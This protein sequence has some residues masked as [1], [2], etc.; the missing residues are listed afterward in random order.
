MSAAAAL[1][2]AARSLLGP[3]IAVCCREIG[4][5]AA[6]LHGEEEAAIARA[7][8]A[9]RA[10]FAAGRAAARAAM[11][12]LGHAPA[13]IPMGGDRAPLWP[14]P[15]TGSITHAGGLALAA[16]AP[17]AACAGLG[18]DLEPDTPLADDLWPGV[19][20]E[21]ERAWLATRPAAIRGNLAKRFFS[22]KEA[23]YK[24]QYA[25]SRKLL[26][27]SDISI[28]WSESDDTFT[29]RLA[30]PVTPFAKGDHIYGRQTTSG[31]MILT[32]ALL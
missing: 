23:A 24:A 30:R 25:R 31:G 15:L 16:L 6:P 13:P 22:A 28:S 14:A 27:F 29:A 17:R 5:R 8:P 9:R 1:Q 18:L 19:L 7:V 10:E 21:A 11:Q 20:L 2:E 4:A 12:T 32:T 3:G 26:D